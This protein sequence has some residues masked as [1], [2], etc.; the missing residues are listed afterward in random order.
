MIDPWIEENPS[1]PEQLR[2]VGHIDIIAITHGHFDHIGD[3]IS[4][5]KKYNPKVVAN[6][7]ICDWLD[8][9]GVQNCIQCNK[10]GNVTIDGIRFTVN[11]RSAQQQHEG[12]GRNGYLWRRTG[13]L[14]NKV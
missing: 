9:K 8:S 13:R 14:H 11:P 12:G 6:W 4:L 5:C 1:C 10:G 2:E 7:E 3:V